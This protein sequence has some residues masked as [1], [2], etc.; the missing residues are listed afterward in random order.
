LTAR[1]AGYA[2]WP[3]VSYNDIGPEM[4]KQQQLNFK[5]IS[6]VYYNRKG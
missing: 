5:I 4:E 1:A 3:I 2:T 6:D